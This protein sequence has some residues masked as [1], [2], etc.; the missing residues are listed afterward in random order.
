[1]HDSRDEVTDK[2]HR[3]SFP[4][5]TGVRNV[6]PD[7][8]EIRRAI[9]FKRFFNTQPYPEEV[10]RI[11][12]SKLENGC[13][14]SDALLESYTDFVFK[15]ESLTIFSIG[16]MLKKQLL[17]IESHP[18]LMKNKNNLKILHDIYLAKSLKDCNILQR[19]IE[20]ASGQG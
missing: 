11:D 1:M 7:V 13:E 5:I 14:P 10:I 4:V 9:L 8:V 17:N 20:T 2:L 6:S 3:D 15:K 16:Y 12:R 18:S 19:A